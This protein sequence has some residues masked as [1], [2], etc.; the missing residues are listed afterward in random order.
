VHTLELYTSSYI[1]HEKLLV[2][3][4]HIP[5]HAHAWKTVWCRNVGNT[6]RSASFIL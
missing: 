6:K 2:Y 1:M 3:S 4:S 5:S